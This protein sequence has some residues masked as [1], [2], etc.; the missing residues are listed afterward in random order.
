MNE[1]SLMPSSEPEPQGNWL[2]SF[3]PS[4][5]VAHYQ[6]QPK[7]IDVAVVRGILFRQRWLIAG[8]VSAVLIAGLVITLLATPMYQASSSVRVEPYSAA[9]VEGQD[10]DGYV[11]PNQIYNL[12][13]THVA[14]IRSQSLARQVAENLNLDERSDFLGEDIDA[15]R[16]DGA[17]DET[18]RA[19]KR[20]MAARILQGS[21]SAEVPRDNWII[22]IA[23]TSPNPVIA[24]E[25]ANAY[26]DAFAAMETEDSL[27]SNE[28]ARE[29]LVEQIDSTRERLQEAEQEANRYAR[30]NGIIVQPVGA[31]AEEGS[32]GTLTTTNLASINMRVAAAQA[33]RIEAEQR[34]RS[35]QNLP[36]TQLAEVQ[37]NALL[38]TL[39]GERTAKLTQLDELRQR[40]LDSHPQIVSTLAQI[41]TLD[42]QIESTSADIKAAIR[43][44]YIV[45]RNREQALQAEL[46]S[47]TGETLAEQDRRVEYGV[48]ERE[49]NALRSQLEALLERF[50][51]ISTASNIRN[52]SI[53][54]LD[55]AS[56]PQ[57][58]YEPSL[59]RNMGLALV[60]GLALAGGLAVLRETLDNRIRSLEDVEERAGLRLLGHTPYL[61]QD[62]IEYESTNRFGPLM[63]AYAS[64][65]ATLDFVIPQSNAVLQLTSSQASEGKSTTAVILAEL[66][67]GSGRKTL[68]IDADLRRPS[69]AS[70]LDVEKPKAG[71]LEVLVGR[72]S[73]EAA[74]VKGVHD[75]LDIIPVVERPANATEVIGS[76]QFS[77]FIEAC[78]RDY[79]MIIIDSAPVLGLADAP[80]LARLVDGTIFVMEANRVNFGQIKDAQRRLQGSG[81]TVIGGILTKYRA[82]EAGDSYGY[83]YSYY[84]Y[85][86]DEKSA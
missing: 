34:W 79:S 74:I 12:L 9:I 78:R 28:Y 66:F 19:R 50:N 81:G 72:S 4:S 44:D 8:V 39:I 30:E 10:L 16:P 26:A 76:S 37:N 46:D 25:V 53:T 38:Q 27:E 47:T 67:A 22:E 7:L 82:L 32:G 21:V 49:A 52:S 77:E 57:A 24:A 31:G 36:A 60:L 23:Y 20:D 15:R 56:V 73:L 33:E 62:D 5:Q 51:Q 18:W 65:Q 17:N 42:S 40:L 48:L 55:H 41:D 86:H 70:L 80:M 58:P 84:R 11:P 1:R 6:S 54:L 85:G 14:V 83:Q 69:I 71:L 59:P 45:A 29:V 75:N 2:D 64:I 63:E 61:P 35:V 3:M 68:L 13:A 43:N